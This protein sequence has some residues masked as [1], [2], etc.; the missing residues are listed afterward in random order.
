LS[1]DQQKREWLN[2]LNPEILKQ[3]K[4]RCLPLDNLRTGNVFNEEGLLKGSY[5][6]EPYIFFSMRILKVGY[7]RQRGHHPIKMLGRDHFDSPFLFNRNFSFGRKQG[8][9]K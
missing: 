6:I 1:S 4:L 3:E 8:K 7:V 5:R 2:K 9:N